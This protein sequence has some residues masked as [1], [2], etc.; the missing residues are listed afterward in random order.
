MSEPSFLGQLRI[1]VQWTADEYVKLI[2]L[3]GLSV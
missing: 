3:F 1:F 2:V